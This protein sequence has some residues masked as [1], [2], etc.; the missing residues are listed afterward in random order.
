[1]DWSI[2]RYERVAAGLLPAAAVVVDHASPR[3]GERVLD[4]G[5]GSGNATLLAAERGAHAIGVDP[6]ERLLEVGRAQAAGRGL[7]V[8]FVAAS[9]EAL[10]VADDAVDVVVSVFGVIFASDP[11]RAVAEIARV[12]RPRGRIAF[13]AWIPSGPVFEVLRMRREAMAAAG[14][15]P[16]PPP[17]PWHERE[18]VASLFAPHGL[19]TEFHEHTLAFSGRGPREFLDAELRDHPVWVASRQT[20]E[21]AGKMQPLYEEALAVV[22]GA[23]EDPDGFRFASRYVVVTAGAI[24]GVQA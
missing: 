10:P 5:C 7:E 11:A 17:F 6:A 8:E 21:R 22:E 24:A 15:P 4:I 13:S 14:A 16:A 3:A 20:L 19:T 9:A 23:N 18:A 12:I 2:G 1:M